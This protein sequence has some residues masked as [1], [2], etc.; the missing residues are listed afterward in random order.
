M[1]LISVA[2]IVLKLVHVLQLYV[3]GKLFW[4]ILFPFAFPYN[5]RINQLNDYRKK[6]ACFI[7]IVL[8][9][10]ITCGDLPKQYGI[11]EFMN[12]A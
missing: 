7:G 10:Q 11:H 12:I 8:K 3:V 9:L 5:F 6:S 4:L 1:V 2:V